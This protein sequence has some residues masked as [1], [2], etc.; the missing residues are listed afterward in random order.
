[1]IIDKLKQYDFVVFDCDGVILDSNEM[2]SEAFAQ[3]LRG[4]SDEL[5][6]Q[7][8]AY[9]KSN[10][11]ISRYK[12]IDYFFHQIKKE[13][14]NVEQ[15]IAD[16]LDKYSAIVKKGLNECSYI[17]GVIETIKT[18]QQENIPLYV[19]S[20]SDEEELNQVFHDRGIKK[21]FKEIYG[22]PKTKIENL[23]KIQKSRGNLA[24]G[25]VLGDSKSDMLAAEFYNLDFMYIH[26][27]SEWKSGKHVVTSK[28][29][30]MYK[31]FLDMFSI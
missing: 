31:N 10:G 4:E 19:V 28:G 14:K 26:E 17:A 24:N 12:K 29:Y 25:V 16:T 1:M 2:K 15:Q 3:S 22:S 5:I 8:I 23:E 20:G 9:H 18:L 7:F 30:S 6:E 27:K 21:Q 13:T 11:G